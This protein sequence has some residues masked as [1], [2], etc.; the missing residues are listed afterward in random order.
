MAKFN[1]ISRKA[2]FCRQSNK[3]SLPTE[4]RLHSKHKTQF[5]VPRGKFKH[6]LF[7]E[8]AWRELYSFAFKP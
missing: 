7:H 8:I 5:S 4:V 6:S 3:I 1:R 2:A